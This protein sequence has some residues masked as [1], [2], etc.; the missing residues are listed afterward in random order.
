MNKKL[1]GTVGTKVKQLG[2]VVATASDE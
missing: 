2:R 1:G